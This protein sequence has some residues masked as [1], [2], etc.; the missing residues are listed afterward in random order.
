MDLVGMRRI[1]ME[2]EHRSHPRRFEVDLFAERPRFE[3]VEGDA[4]RPLAV[5]GAGPEAVAQPGEVAAERS[6]ANAAEAHPGPGT[7]RPD[8]PAP[9]D[10]PTVRAGQ[11]PEVEA[12]GPPLVAVLQTEAHDVA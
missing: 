11:R 6:V 7:E 10:R 4:G 1:S 5:E 9:A 2:A 8:P 3:V 12:L